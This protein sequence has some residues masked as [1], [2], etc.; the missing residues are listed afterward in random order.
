MTTHSID[1]YLRPT[2]V[3]EIIADLVDQYSRDGLGQ[4]EVNSLSEH[5]D[6][7]MAQLVDLV[8]LPDALRLVTSTVP[9]A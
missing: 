4:A 6:E 3:A 9:R 7:Q 1:Q 5:I 2:T 8:G